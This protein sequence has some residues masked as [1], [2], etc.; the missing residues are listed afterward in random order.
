MN[1]KK[2]ILI[3]EDEAIAVMTME[4]IFEEWGF[5]IC[6]VASNGIEA[7][8]CVHKNQPDIVLMDINLQGDM[9]GLEVAEKI[10]SICNVMTIFITGYSPKEYLERVAHLPALAILEKP[11]DYDKLYSIINGI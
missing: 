3:V 2:K 11:I 6:G 8:E 7:I 1:V 4:D 10:S 9:D 5:E